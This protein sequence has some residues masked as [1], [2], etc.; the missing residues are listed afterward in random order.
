MYE[1]W[2][3]FYFSLSLSQDLASSSFVFIVAPVCEVFD[4]GIELMDIKYTLHVCSSSI[5]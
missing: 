1:Y 3:E 4:S 2:L 5:D